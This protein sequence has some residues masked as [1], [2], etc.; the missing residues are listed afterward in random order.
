MLILMLILLM[1]VATVSYVLNDRHIGNASTIMTGIFFISSFVA[2]LN[3]NNWKFR[4][5]GFTVFIIISSILIFLAGELLAKYIVSKI[6]QNSKDVTYVQIT[7]PQPGYIVTLFVIVAMILMFMYYYSQVKLLAYNYSGKNN[8]VIYYAREAVVSGQDLNKIAN[9]FSC[10]AQCI[11]YI[12]ATF[13]IYNIINKKFNF[14]IILYIVPMFIYLLF[15]AVMGVRTGYIYIITFLFIT[16]CFF[17]QNKCGWV[18]KSSIKL[19]VLGGISLIIFLF[20]FRLTGFLKYSGVGTTAFKSISK[21]TAFS[22]PA[23]D[24]FLQ[25]HFPPNI[26]FGQY[27]LNRVYSITNQLHITNIEMTSRFLPFYDLTEEVSSNIYTALARYIQD[28]GYFGNYIIM[29]I[30]GLLYSFG[31]YMIKTRRKVGI[32]IIIYAMEFYPIVLMSIDEVFFNEVMTTTLVYQMVYLFMVFYALKL[33]SSKNIFNTLKK[34]K[35]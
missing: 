34:K 26:Y 16:I 18:T 12:F 21:Y 35:C 7:L 30:M 1:V 25:N 33:I 27:N 20:I 8:D 11:A 19:V 31:W 23:F 9:H 4:L 6:N 24:H 15:Y 14:N 13:F 5:H 32:G 10:L 22:I 29:F 2:L 28:F 3:I 17:Y